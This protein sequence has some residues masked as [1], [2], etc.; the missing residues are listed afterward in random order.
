MIA[1]N[2]DE[3][4]EDVRR[5]FAAWRADAVRPRKYALLVADYYGD[6]YCEGDDPLPGRELVRWVAKSADRPLT[7]AE[8]EA[9]AGCAERWERWTMR[10][11]VGK[12][13]IYDLFLHEPVL[14]LRA[15]LFDPV[16]V[17]ER[18][19]DTE[20]GN[21]ITLRIMECLRPADWVWPAPDWTPPP[22]VVAW[23][24]RI[25]EQG[26]FGDLPILADL[27]EDHGC[28]DRPL[29]D[30]CRQARHCR[31]CAALDRILGVEREDSAPH[32]R[33]HG[34]N[35]LEGRVWWYTHHFEVGVVGG[36]FLSDVRP[37]SVSRHHAVVSPHSNGW[38]LA[39][40]GSTNGTRLNGTPLGVRVAG[41]LRAG[42]ALQFG[43]AAVRV[44][45]AAPCVR[46]GE[47]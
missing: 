18:L 44:A 42:D 30:H 13:S 12:C 34:M 40:A 23:A 29:L 17:A 46:E 20:C 27:L 9:A 37:P 47:S 15:A 5:R 16:P 24:R 1:E 7:D 8:R 3:L 21:S 41:P 36:R 26:A 28:P 4:R 38:R 14:S 11:Q 6:Y 19:L 22:E 45:F 33:F 25:G 43:S 2:E 31:G 10:K 35:E 32:L 39:D